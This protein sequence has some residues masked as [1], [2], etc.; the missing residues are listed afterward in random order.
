MVG[1]H[2]T[3]GKQRTQLAREATGLNHSELGSFGF[4]TTEAP[5]LPFPLYS[6]HSRYRENA[7]KL[8]GKQN[9]FWKI[10]D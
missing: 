5:A 2:E 1:E 9:Y 8:L 10:T 3:C 6:S 4:K 7:E